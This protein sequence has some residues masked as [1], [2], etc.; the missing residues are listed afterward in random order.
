MPPAGVEAVVE[1]RVRHELRRERRQQDAAS[2]MAGCVH[3]VRH[4]GRQTQNRQVVG[5]ARAQS[6]ARTHEGRVQR[7]R[8]DRARSRL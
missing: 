8:R 2:I 5:R 6:R 1:Q 7:V 4:D 3:Q